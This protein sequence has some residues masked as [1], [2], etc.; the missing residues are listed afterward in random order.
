MSYESELCVMPV[1]SNPKYTPIDNRCFRF[2]VSIVKYADILRSERRFEISSQI[3]RSVNSV[4]PNTREANNAVSKPDFLNKIAIA[5]K[6]VSETIFW[7]ELMAEIRDG[8]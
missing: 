8:S 7:L 6:E 4:G 5:Q 1:N 2:A 3:I